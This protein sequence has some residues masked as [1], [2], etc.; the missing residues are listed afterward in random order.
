MVAS[1]LSGMTAR[2]V[3]RFR[4]PVPIVGMTTDEKTWRKLS[5]S[6]GVLPSLS[7][8]YNSTDVLFYEAKK[9]AK[10]TIGLSKGDKVVMTGGMTNGSSGNTNMIKVEIV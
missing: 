8:M 6:W 4:C 10:Q 1:T 5:L 3:S 9:L 7:E 2:M